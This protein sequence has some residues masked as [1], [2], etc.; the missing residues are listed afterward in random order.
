MEKCRLQHRLSTVS[1]WIKDILNDVQ[2]TP[3]VEQPGTDIAKAVADLNKA[4]CRVQ[5]LTQH[6]AKSG[7]GATFSSSR[8]NITNLEAALPSLPRIPNDLLA[9]AVFTHPGV[10]SNIKA[11]YDRLE[12][13]GD[14]Y[15][16]LMAT[17]LI[18]DKFGDITSGRISQIRELLVKNETLA[19]Y[20]TKY[21]FDK[22]AHVP[23]DY[24]TQP[25]RWMKT[26][27]DIFESYVA[28]IIL[29]EPQNGY[30]IAE[31]WLTQLWLPK[32]S[33]IES[34]KSFLHAKEA[35]AQKIMGKGVKLRYIDEQPCAQERRGVQTFC[36]GVYLTGWGW[37]NRHL[38]S[39]QGPSKAI[40]GNEAALQALA[41][42]AL[43]KSI[44]DVKKAHAETKS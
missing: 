44:G 4:L 38:G 35:L 36:I 29:S 40:A 6:V 11:T 32:L 27:G 13:L 26:M 23:H 33:G 30:K 39:G 5:S 21:G 7:A 41:N 3:E 16:E 9:N 1:D 8:T 15:I 14:A 42:E 19:E 43:I 22:R 10:N 12:V 37:V 2:C 28:A 25:R 17:R 20:A 18:W 34:Q 24:L 31:E